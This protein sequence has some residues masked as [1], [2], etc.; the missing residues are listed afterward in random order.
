MVSPG[1]GGA[2]YRVPARLK[3]CVGGHDD[4]DLRGSDAQTGSEC[5]VLLL[6][7]C[8]QSHAGP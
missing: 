4:D 8:V 7:W 5:S 1:G 6:C 3:R 2:G